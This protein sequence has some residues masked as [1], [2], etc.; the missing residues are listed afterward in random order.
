MPLIIVVLRIVFA[1]VLVL[2]GGTFTMIG[3]SLIYGKIQVSEKKKNR[4]NDILVGAILTFIG[5]LFITYA[6]KLFL[7]FMV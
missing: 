6:V 1:G 3:T 7:T 2:L 5:I 4:L